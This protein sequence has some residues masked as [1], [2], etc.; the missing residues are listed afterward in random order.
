M[1]LGG[2]ILEQNTLDT[3]EQMLLY[4]EEFKRYSIEQVK[5]ASS[6]ILYSK[7]QKIDRIKSA[8]PS[9]LWFQRMKRHNQEKR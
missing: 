9:M 1:S 8:T 3:I 4:S 5:L 2:P 6:T 7:K